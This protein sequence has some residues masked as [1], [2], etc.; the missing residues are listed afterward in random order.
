MAKFSNMQKLVKTRKEYVVLICSRRQML[1]N[2]R[3]GKVF[4]LHSSFR[5]FLLTIF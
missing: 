3:K 2:N 5:F 1:Q 4:R